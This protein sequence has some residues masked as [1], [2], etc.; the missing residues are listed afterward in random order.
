VRCYINKLQTEFED[1]KISKEE[2]SKKI[3]N[4]VQSEEEYE[5]SIADY[6]AE[7]DYIEEHSYIGDDDQVYLSQAPDI[8]LSYYESTLLEAYQSGLITKEGFSKEFAR[9]SKGDEKKLDIFY[10]RGYISD[11]DY[12]QAIDAIIET[13]QQKVQVL[14]AKKA[15]INKANSIANNQNAIEK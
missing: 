10:S 14:E 1:G 6:Y 2:L 4:Y 3:I 9:R 11:D 13:Y 8:V 12:A 5:H 15:S 7:K